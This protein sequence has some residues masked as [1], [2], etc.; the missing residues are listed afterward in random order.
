[1]TDPRRADLQRRTGETD[2]SLSIALEGTGAGERA[3]GIG[4]F[5]HMLELLARHGHLDLTVRASGDLHTGGHHT[6]EDVG[7]CLGEALHVALGERRGIARYGQATVP[8]DEARAACAIDISGRG[9]C[10]F[11][12]SLPQGAIG[13]F[14]YELCEEFMRALA[15]HARITLHL[16]IEAGTNVHHM[17]EAAFKATARALRAA[18]AI[19]PSETGIPSTKGSLV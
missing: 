6:V 14:D 7:I 12:A 15:I 17:I 4:F 18:T 13:E 5:D 3:T 9:L 16:T 11:E 19:D 1:M 10:A 8:M 2:I